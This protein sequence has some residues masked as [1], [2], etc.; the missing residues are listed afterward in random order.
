MAEDDVLL[1]VGQVKVF[2]CRHHGRDA[3]RCPAAI[4]TV[5]VESEI[6]KE[7]ATR[8]LPFVE[9]EK[10]RKPIRDISGIHQVFK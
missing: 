9:F 6:V 2:A 8:R 5:I 1:K 3:V 7:S 10:A 4:D